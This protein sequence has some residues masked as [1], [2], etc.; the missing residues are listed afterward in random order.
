MIT[1]FK[2]YELKYKL[3]EQQVN[4][5]R[6][7]TAETMQKDEYGFY[8]I[9]NL[10]L[11]TATNLLIR[12]SIE[13]PVYKEKLRV[14]F[15]DNLDADTLAFFEL[16][17]KYKNVVY[18]RRV[19]LNFNELIE[20]IDNHNLCDNTQ[21]GREINYTLNAYENLVPKVQLT[22][23]REAYKGDGELRLTI[24]SN[25]CYKYSDIYNFDGTGEALN[26]GLY[27]LEIKTDKG[28]PFWL[29]KFLNTNKIYRTPF[30]K[31]GEVYQK[32]RLEGVI[33][34]DYV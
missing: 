22:Y 11:D 15:Y 1:T 19:R 9:N 23:V 27:I 14:R 16:K 32:L 25:I 33:N 13:K 5:L 20:K 3:T 24:D 34:D 17:K 28:F 26:D 12:R 30:S 7:L 2:R 18:K 31:Y 29:I 8:K 4:S 10:Y 6:Q 21:I